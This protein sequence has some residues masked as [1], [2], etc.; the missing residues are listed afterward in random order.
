M[1][2]S[3]FPRRQASG[4]VTEGLSQKILDMLNSLRAHLGP[5][6]PPGFCGKNGP[7]LR[8]A[9]QKK[10]GGDDP[11]SE[12]GRGWVRLGLG[13]L[14]GILIF[15]QA[16]RLNSLEGRVVKYMLH[17]CDGVSRQRVQNLLKKNF[18]LC[19]DAPDV[20]SLGASPKTLCAVYELRE[21]NLAV[22]IVE[23]PELRFE[24][25]SSILR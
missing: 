11:A 2:Q 4:S 15:A 14:L 17:R 19:L 6:F 3:T 20:Q 18:Q 8:S 16:S 7:F 10:G 22:T 5:Y 25:S 1:F 9:C 23:K 24:P 13:N 21:G 12:H